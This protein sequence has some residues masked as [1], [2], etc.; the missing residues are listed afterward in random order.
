MSSSTSIGKGY[1]HMWTRTLFR[2]LSRLR[3]SQPRCGLSGY[4]SDT[5]DEEQRRKLVVALG[6]GIDTRGGHAAGFLSINK[7]AI[8]YCKKIGKWIRA[9]QRF[10]TT[11]AEGH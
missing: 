1:N 5:L 10:L 11:A 9:K 6:I 7:H 4:A 2:L 3:F 8:K